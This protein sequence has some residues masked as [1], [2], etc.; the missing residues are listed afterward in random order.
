MLGLTYGFRP[1]YS[2]SRS[3]CQRSDRDMRPA[4]VWSIGP[5]RIGKFKKHASAH[6]AAGRKLGVSASDLADPSSIQNG[7]DKPDAASA[8][9]CR[10]GMFSTAAPAVGHCDD[11]RLPWYGLVCVFTFG[12]LRGAL[13]ARPFSMWTVH[14][15]AARIPGAH[16]AGARRQ[17]QARAD[18]DKAARNGPAIA[19]R[20]A[21]RSIRG[22]VVLTA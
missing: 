20:S 1:S 17:S 6:I 13:T 5:G 11:V 22:R 18:R 16:G 4:E 14:R 15:H 10:N 3:R 19:G 12:S 21:R 7:R 2:L 9:V 8:L